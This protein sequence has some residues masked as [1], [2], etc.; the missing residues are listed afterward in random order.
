MKLIFSISSGLLERLRKSLGVCDNTE[1]FSRALKAMCGHGDGLQ[2]PESV[3]DGDTISVEVEVS[4][5]DWARASGKLDEAS[6]AEVMVVALNC[7]SSAKESAGDELSIN[8]Q[9]FGRYLVEQK[10]VDLKMLMKAVRAANSQGVRLG[11]LAVEKNFLSREKAEYINSQQAL[12]K[13]PFGTLALGEKLLTEAQIVELVG[14]QKERRG[15]VGE[16]LIKLGFVTQEAMAKYF[17]HFKDTQEPTLVGLDS[18]AGKRVVRMILEIFPELSKSLAGII[19][20]VEPEQMILPRHQYEYTAAITMRGDATCTVTLSVNRD[21]AKVIMWGLFG[22]DYVEMT[23]MYP[24]GVGEFLNMLLGN[25]GRAMDKESIHVQGDAPDFA[26][27]WP[28]NGKALA[29][30]VVGQIRPGAT[31]VT[32]VEPMAKGSLILSDL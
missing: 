14:L 30:A 4:D 20:E 32:P 13:K 15:G 8:S 7:L 29:F 23:E 24:D 9:I 25:A 12:T 28:E 5:E 2:V 21:F 10:V 1:L 17:A 31:E 26:P 3:D 22:L 6:P 27:V 11:D 19:V 18:T 16:A